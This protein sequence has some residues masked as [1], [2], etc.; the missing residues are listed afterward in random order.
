MKEQ[1]LEGQG[2]LIPTGRTREGLRFKRRVEESDA[3]GGEDGGG[4]EAF[5]IPWDAI[6]SSPATCEGKSL[7]KG[8]THH[9]VSGGGA[10]HG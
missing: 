9:W 5:L 7:Y 2:V 8:R 4:G 1:D 6:E 10:G 3:G